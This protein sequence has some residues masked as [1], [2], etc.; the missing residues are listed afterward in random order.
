MR[1]ESAI[2]AAVAL[3][4]LVLGAG[5]ASAQTI[6]KNPDK[7]TTYE[8]ST[9]QL[10][11]CDDVRYSAPVR[12][13]NL[14]TNIVEHQFGRPEQECVITDPKVQKAAAQQPTREPTDIRMSKVSTA[15]GDKFSYE[16]TDFDLE[17]PDVHIETETVQFFSGTQKNAESLENQLRSTSLMM[18]DLRTK[19]I[20]GEFK[21]RAEM[22]IGSCTENKIVHTQ[23]NEVYK[24]A[25]G[26]T[27]D[28]FTP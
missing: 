27:F 8:R 17:G 19:E 16:I 11:S 4:G 6:L 21:V 7:I 9:P 23:T 18:S 28:C 10:P 3:G 20:G 26:M 14:D 13:V 1:L 22:P 5:A 12:A 24:S 25:K 2:T 15:G